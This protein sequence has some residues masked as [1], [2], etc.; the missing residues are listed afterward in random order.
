MV[1]MLRQWADR[2]LSSQGGKK[3]LEEG[4]ELLCRCGQWLWDVGNQNDAIEAFKEVVRICP[5]YVRAH[6]NLGVAYWNLGERAS[7]V[8]HFRIARDLDP[9]NKDAV[10]NC[11]QIMA[12]VGEFVSARYLFESFLRDYGPDRE[13]ATALVDLSLFAS[14]KAS[15]ARAAAH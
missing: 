8:R 7:A 3:R 6:N 5:S 9:S 14:H 12:E 11:G 4:I 2:A 13:I 10:W 1:P 15:S